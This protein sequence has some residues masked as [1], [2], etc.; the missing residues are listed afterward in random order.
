MRRELEEAVVLTHPTIYRD[1]KPCSADDQRFECGDGWFQ[2]IDELSGK[3]E[4][5]SSTQGAD[6]LAVV[7]VKEKLGELRI[8]FRGT[9]SSRA[10]DWISGAERESQST[11][12]LCGQPGVLLARG[13]GVLQTRCH[14]CAQAAAAR[15][16]EH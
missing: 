16:A 11:C 12:E 15:R 7:Q 14:S 1:L 6:K 3:L 2:I 13:A 5:E 10:R 8:Y 9:V 4:A